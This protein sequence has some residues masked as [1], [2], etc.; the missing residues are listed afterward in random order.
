MEQLA[1]HPNAYIRQS[2]SHGTLGGITRGTHEAV[3]LC[4][5]AGYDIIIIETVG[6][7]SL[8][9]KSSPQMHFFYAGVGQSEAAVADT[10]DMFVL[11]LS[12]AHG[13]ELQVIEFNDC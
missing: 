4:E 7:L 10:V 5:A 6:A 8:C 9:Q 13:D 3:M 12:P 2:P 11:L 1:R